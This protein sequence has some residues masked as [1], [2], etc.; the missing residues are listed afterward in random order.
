[1]EQKLKEYFHQELS[2]LDNIFNGEFKELYPDILKKSKLDPDVN[3]LLRG[4]A[5]LTAII[6]QKIDDD[7]P[8]IVQE[9]I[10]II[11]PHQLRPVPSM[12]IISFKPNKTLINKKIIEREKTSLK[13]KPVKYE[14][15]LTNCLFRT[16]YDVEIHPLELLSASLGENSECYPTIKLSFKYKGLDINDWQISKLRLYISGKNFVEATN[17]FFTLMVYLN[18]FIIKTENEVTEF[19]KEMFEPV[20]FSEDDAVIPY[21]ANAFWAYRVLQE[22]FILPQKFLFV[23][24]KGLDSWKTK[25]ETFDIIFELKDIPN[26]L[27]SINESNFVLFA[28]PAINLFSCD[29]NPITLDHKTKKYRLSPNTEEYCQVFSIENI[30]GHIHGV[31][32]K[33][34]YVSFDNI[35]GKDSFKPVYTTHIEKESTESNKDEFNLSLSFL[36]NDKLSIQK[37][38]IFADLLCTNGFLPERLEE[39]SITE[40]TYTSPDKVIFENIIACTH[41]ILPP[42][43]KNSLWHLISHLSL[44]YLS[45]EKT[46]NLKSLLKNFSTMNNSAMGNQFSTNSSKKIESIEKVSSK[47]FDEIVDGVMMRGKEITIEA[48]SDFFMSKGDFY[49]FGCILNFFISSY[50]S[51]NTFTKLVLKDVRSK[52]ISFQ[53]KSKIGERIQI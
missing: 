45:L 51:L 10:R 32:K 34:E 53:W 2:L 21:P 43:N 36:Y 41:N 19:Q 20:G 3:S 52:N 38:T 27:T 26:I 7:F 17:L 6:K 16:C 8:E 1:M 24:L 30:I 49:L 46:N 29:A 28:T 44:N 35:I 13:S 25:S 31:E 5:Y 39:G 12:T 14:G 47:P 9:L 4:V 42:D 18:K 11:F 15:R 23:D 40:K 50:A 37:E 22:Y 33:R 48:N